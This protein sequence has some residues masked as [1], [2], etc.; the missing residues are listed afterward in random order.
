TA[1]TR[2]RLDLRPFKV[3]HARHEG[4]E[5]ARVLL[6]EVDIDGAFIARRLSL[7]VHGEKCLRHA[8]E[9][10]EIAA[11]EELVVLGAD[12]RLRQS[13]HLNQRLRVSEA[14]EA[15]LS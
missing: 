5:A 10:G 1:Q 9:H 12:L 4:L 6:D 3:V 14:L 2:T 7:G 15:T 13:E 8:D 11:W